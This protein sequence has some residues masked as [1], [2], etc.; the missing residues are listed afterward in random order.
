[1][2][3]EAAKQPGEED[4]ADDVRSAPAKKFILRADRYDRHDPESYIQRQAHYWAYEA[5]PRTI[6]QVELAKSVPIEAMADVSA[7]PLQLPPSVVARML[8][9]AEASR[10]QSP[11]SMG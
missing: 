6:P 1:M 9:R 5:T 11:R 8:K 7:K 4:D 3:R 2:M 10:Q